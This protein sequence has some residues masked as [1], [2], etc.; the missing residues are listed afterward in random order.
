MDVRSAQTFGKK[1][2]WRV[3]TRFRQKSF[4]GKFCVKYDWNKFM[5][6]GPG[7]RRFLNIYTSDPK[8]FADAS[9]SD[10]AFLHFS[11]KLQK[12]FQT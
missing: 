6:T 4:C 10:G 2:I 3:F 1:N 9:E 12:C 7:S 5:L 11:A 8:H